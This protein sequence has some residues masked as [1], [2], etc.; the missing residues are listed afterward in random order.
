LISADILL[1][2]LANV[3]F[4]SSFGS[5]DICLVRV[6]SGPDDEVEAAPEV[7][8]NAVSFKLP[9]ELFRVFLQLFVFSES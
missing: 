7:S 4:F 6:L 9:S 1:S 2:S 3:T 8:V 5:D